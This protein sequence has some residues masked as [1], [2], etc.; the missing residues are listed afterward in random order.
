ML[1]ASTNS[2]LTVSLLTDNANLQFMAV[3]PWQSNNVTSAILDLSTL[4]NSTSFS[5]TNFVMIPG[6]FTN[7]LP[8][9]IVLN[10][11][12]LP[13]FDIPVSTI[14]TNDCLDFLNG[15]PTI[16]ISQ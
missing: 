15:T 9:D 10:L 13:P 7:Q 14:T 6:C 12:G 2:L 8:I 4:T 3:A 16:D 5:T 11:G 1:V